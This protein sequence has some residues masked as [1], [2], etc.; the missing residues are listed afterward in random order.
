[1]VS[2]NDYNLSPVLLNCGNCHLPIKYEDYDLSLLSLSKLQIDSIAN[3]NKHR[4]DNETEK[5]HNKDFQNSMVLKQR[6]SSKKLPHLKYHSAMSAAPSSNGN[7]FATDLKSSSYVLL[8]NLTSNQAMNDSINLIAQSNSN[9]NSVLL[10]DDHVLSRNVKALESIFQILNDGLDSGEENGQFLPHIKHPMCKDCC[11]LLLKKLTDQYMDLLAEKEKYQDFLK[12]LEFH[13]HRISNSDDKNS[14]MTR[15]HDMTNESARSV[16]YTISPK[17]KRSSFGTPLTSPK[18]LEFKSPTSLSQQDSTLSANDLDNLKE[19]QHIEKETQDLS[20]KL[21]ELTTEGDK[22]EVSLQKEKLLLS[23][24]KKDYLNKLNDMNNEKIIKYNENLSA[25]TRL[26]TEVEKVHDDLSNLRNLN[27]Y[28]TIF[29]IST[30]DSGSALKTQILQDSASNKSFNGFGTINGLKI[31]FNWRET[32][33]ALGQVILCLCNLSIPI[34]ES[35]FNDELTSLG[36]E[37]YPIGSVSKIVKQ[38]IEYDCFYDPLETSSVT[39]MKSNNSSSKNLTNV[40]SSNNNNNW[41]FLFF[42]NSAQHSPDRKESRINKLRLFN[43]A[44]IIILHQIEVLLDYLNKV[45]LEY[46]RAK[47]AEAEDRNKWTLPYTINEDKINS[48]SI[49]YSASSSVNIE[50]ALGCKFMLVNLKYLMI[51]RHKLF[52]LKQQ[53]QLE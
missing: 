8:D 42:K 30:S 53:N 24:M 28:N 22:L 35:I 39:S 52:Q 1:M 41:N 26:S 50:W 31:G 17:K 13:K 43:E 19:I 40:S 32:N 29:N 6:L 12:K 36:V 2:N 18:K 4:F 15:K 47:D 48:V 25:W 33:A 44:M 34:K 7:K 37:W 10:S 27:I 9:N 23:K 5:H 14:V 38:G 49:K 16:A 3:I 21:E 11:D 46:L 51:Y 45:K 20:K